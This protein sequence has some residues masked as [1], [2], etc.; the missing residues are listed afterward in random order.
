[1]VKDVI[2]LDIKN[3]QNGPFKIKELYLNLLEN[4][5]T[6]AT[7]ERRKLNKIMWDKRISIILIEKDDMFSTYKLVYNAR[8]EIATYNSYAMRESVKELLEEL[9]KE[10]S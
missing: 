7:N 10:G 9:I 5:H 3:I 6:A 8:E 4:M 1:M 2:Q